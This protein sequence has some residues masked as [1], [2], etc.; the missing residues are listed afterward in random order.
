MTSEHDKQ[1]YHEFEEISSDVHKYTPSIIP[2][3]YES[4]YDIHRLITNG[5]RGMD[6]CQ[7]FEQEIYGKRRFDEI[8]KISAKQLKISEIRQGSEAEGVTREE[9]VIITIPKP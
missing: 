4:K 8:E 1:F 7:T 9:G 2:P 5:P 6:P 3:S